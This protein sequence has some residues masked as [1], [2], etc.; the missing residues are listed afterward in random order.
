MRGIVLYSCTLLLESVSIVCRLLLVSFLIGIIFGQTT[1]LVVGGIAAVLPVLLSLLVLSGLPSGH[2]LLRAELRG[3]KPTKDEWARL[4]AAFD[5][6]LGRNA[7]LPRHIFVLDRPGINAAVSGTTLYIYRETITS[8]YLPA[9]LAHELGHLYARDGRL[10]LALRSLTVP[11]GFLMANTL[12]VG[13]RMLMYVV[14]WL[15]QLMLVPLYWLVGSAGI[16]LVAWLSY[17]LLGALP[18][19]IVIFAMGGLSVQLLEAGWQR[20][21]IDAEYAADAYAASLGEAPGLIDLFTRLS[22]VDVEIPWST[23]A[24]H[25][26]IP[27]RIKYLREIAP[28]WPQRP[29]SGRMA[30]NQYV[31]VNVHKYARNEARRGQQQRRRQMLRYGGIVLGATVFVV[32][33]VL[34]VIMLWP[35]APA[36]TPQIVTPVPVIEPEGMSQ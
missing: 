25:P 4:Q 33:A 1:G 26:P 16:R 12:I 35:S 21:A 8:R 34:A 5:R 7:L 28:T 29:V 31:A 13:I 20:Y 17:I 24:T 11:G 36:F 19:Q 9:V 18:R 10:L 30:L 2:L 22:F 15:L 23:R 32:T 27:M 3:R 6:I 14:F